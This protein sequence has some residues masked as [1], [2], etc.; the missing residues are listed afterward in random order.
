MKT[1]NKKCIFCEGELKYIYDLNGYKIVQ[2]Q[3]C[4]TCTVAEMP[5][6]SV[7]RDFYNGFGYFADDSC[8]AKIVNPDFADWFKSFNLPENAKM[9][10]IGGG[11]GHFSSCFE[12]FGNGRATYIDLDTKACEYVKSTGI[13]D[14]IND[15]VCNLAQNVN[16]KFDF[17]Y[18][19]HVIEHLVDPLKIIDSAIELLSE[20]GVFVLQFPNGLSFE[21]LLEKEYCRT[22]RHSLRYSNKNLSKYE[23]F[24][25]LHS[26]KAA[27]DLDPVRHLWAISP[28][29]ISTYLKRKHKS[30][31]FTVKTYS[32]DDKIYSPYVNEEKSLKSLFG[33]V[34]SLI[35]GKAHV[36]VEIRKI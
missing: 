32:L 5:S 18:S 6:P 22:R 8:K 23:I 19:R 28:K 16:Q 31:K 9:L 17:I 33:K 11:G 24:K 15:D 29:A 1:D 20:E 13:Q 25:I 3:H 12:H 27:A 10:D 4:S 34:L 35:N 36:V 14:V 7:L 2:C 30:V 21:R 26:N